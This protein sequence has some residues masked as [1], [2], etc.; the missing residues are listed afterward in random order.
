MNLVASLIVHNERDR[1]LGPCINHLME[2]CDEVRV[3]DDGSD[4][5]SVA[6]AEKLGASVY[7]SFQH[8]FFEHEG[9]TRQ[10]LLEW[11][12]E[13]DPTHIL[14]IDADE[15]VADGDLVRAAC[16]AREEVHTLVMEEVW[17]LDG[18]CLCI[19][20]DGGWVPHSIPALYHVPAERDASWAI[21]D[22]P[23]ACGREPYAVR[24][25]SSHARPTGTE[26]LHFGWANES[27]RAA[28]H[29][30]YA[31]ADGGRFHASSHLD[32]ILW[33]PELIYLRPRSWP[34][35]LAD[36][37]SAIEKRVNEIA[38]EADGLASRPARDGS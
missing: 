9:R 14:S 5:D 37:R 26:I 10:H 28:R 32:S 13:A 27:E 30:R 17:E 21:L 22:V 11:T 20:E 12:L 6:V 25:A 33:P 36:Y 31:V 7:H 35:G 1:F 15:F 16:L 3:W 2:F 19:R 8:E 38:G 24:A 4:D 23:L 34:P 18:E 29:E